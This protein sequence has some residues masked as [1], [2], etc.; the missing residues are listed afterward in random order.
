VVKCETADVVEGWPTAGCGPAMAGGVL[1][2]RA[3]RLRNRPTAP[4]AL[5]AQGQTAGSCRISRRLVRTSRLGGVSEGEAQALG[6]G[7]SELSRRPRLLVHAVRSWAM[8]TVS[9]HAAFAAKSGKGK[10]ARRCP[11]LL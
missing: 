11:W 1:I 2:G 5:F 3:G 9:S 4:A 10:L 8:S 6:L 7:G